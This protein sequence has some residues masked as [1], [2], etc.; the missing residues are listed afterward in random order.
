[1]L[2]FRNNLTR[3]KIT[4]EVKHFRTLKGY[5][6]LCFKGYVPSTKKTLEKKNEAKK[7]LK[8]LRVGGCF[9]GVGFCPSW[10]LIAS[11]WNITRVSCNLV[12]AQQ[13]RAIFC[14]FSCVFREEHSMD[15]CR[16]RPKLSENFERHWSIRISGEIHMDQSL[17]HTFSWGNS[18][19]PKFF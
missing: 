15:Q 16:S 2:F 5:F 19:G 7:N 1:M 14:L 13:K 6:K 12:F 3:P 10:F 9:L 4:S 8:M 17:V 11:D 18:Y